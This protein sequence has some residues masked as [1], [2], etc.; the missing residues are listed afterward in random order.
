[1][2]GDKKKDIILVIIIIVI[3]L[4]IGYFSW[5]KKS[6]V[7][8]TIVVAD[9]VYMVTDHNRFFTVTS[10]ISK[11]LSYLTMHDTQN[12][13]LLLDDDYKNENNITSD[14]LY[15]YINA[16]DEEQ[17]FTAKKMYQE[18]VNDHII[19]YYVSGILQPNLL[20]STPEEYATIDSTPF[21]IIVNLDF[22][23]Q[24]FSIVPYDGKLFHKEETS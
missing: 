10:C 11:Y 22:Q 9:N 2:I 21:Y 12:I 20:L 15:D 3:I 18:T 6:T 24:V 1:M 13:L 7:P 19:K 5:G 17:E 23:R 8:N 4:L 14:N 16:F